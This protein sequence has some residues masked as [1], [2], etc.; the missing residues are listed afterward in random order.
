MGAL[1]GVLDRAWDAGKGA[2]CIAGPRS[3]SRV[4]CVKPRQRGL[5]AV[6]EAFGR[7]PALADRLGD[8]RALVLVA[9]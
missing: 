4:G 1:G 7:F 2:D 5:E 6:L 8:S 9:I 3:R